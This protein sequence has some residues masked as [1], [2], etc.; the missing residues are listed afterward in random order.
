MKRVNVHQKTAKNSFQNISII[1]ATG[2]VKLQFR[3]P[4]LFLRG[5]SAKI[6]KKKKK[7]CEISPTMV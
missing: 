1:K 4:L 5:F 2:N 7:L 3:F 6:Q